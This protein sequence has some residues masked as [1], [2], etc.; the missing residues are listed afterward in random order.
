MCGLKGFVPVIVAKRH[1]G[2]HSKWSSGSEQCHFKKN[3]FV[4][5]TLDDLDF[6]VAWGFELR[7]LHSLNRDSTS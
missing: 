5:Y 1:V 3:S 2:I 7:A 6:F 4:P